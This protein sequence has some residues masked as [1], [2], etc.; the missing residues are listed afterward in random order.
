MDPDNPSPGG[1][2][3]NGSDGGPGGDGGNGGS[4]P[5]V[6]VQVALHAGSHPL[7]EAARVDWMGLTRGRFEEPVWPPMKMLVFV[8][9]AIAL[10]ESAP[11][12][13]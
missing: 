6:T 2:G 13:P 1:N 4:A 3:G 7:L 11:A 10:A 9:S 12:P 5:N 8:S